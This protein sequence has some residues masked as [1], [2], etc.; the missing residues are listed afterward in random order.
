M[1]GD[2]SE[3]GSWV[4]A[5]LLDPGS[6]EK[7][8]SHASDT[9]Q[10]REATDDKANFGGDD[11][12]APRNSTV[13]DEAPPVQAKNDLESKLSLSLDDLIRSKHTE[14]DA[15]WRTEKNGGDDHG[16]DK[17][18]KA[19]SEK[20]GR[21]DRKQQGGYRLQHSRKGLK[22]EAASVLA[23]EL[24]KDSES[25]SYSELDFSQNELTAE[26]FRSVVEV[27]KACAGNLK[28]LK[29][30]K[31]R[32]GDG[33]ADAFGELLRHCPELREVHLSHN[34]LSSQGVIDLA[35]AARRSRKAD[36]PL[37]LR[38]EQNVG[39]SESSV[40]L[41]ILEKRCSACPRKSECTQFT[42]A[43]G[44]TLHVPFLDNA[45]ISGRGWSRGRDREYSTA[46]AQSSG[47]RNRSRPR[48]VFL[49]S[50]SRRRRNS[51][52]AAHSRLKSSSRSR[53]V[54]VRK[55]RSRSRSRHAMLRLQPA[56]GRPSPAP[57]R[58][59]EPSP[60]PLR[61]EELSPGSDT[62]RSPAPQKR[63]RERRRSRSAAKSRADRREDTVLPLLPRRGSR[64]KRRR[65]NRS[66]DRTSRSTR[67]RPR[68]PPRASRKESRDR[69]D[70]SRGRR[71]G[72]AKEA[73]DSAL[74]TL[75]SMSTQSQA[76]R[77]VAPST[78]NRNNDENLWKR[79]DD[80]L[81]M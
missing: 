46:G 21:E 36:W 18:W 69:R 12:E 3:P 66:R 37:W 50:P 62:R 43:M 34:C 77:D 55:G 59:Q 78:S 2:E 52:S 25:L 76:C 74:A 17:N 33:A 24:L 56:Q 44:S 65:E 64:S 39:Q 19:E 16:W 22:D 45:K 29:L 28:V 7:S 80:L 1:L 60:V 31:N 32:I 61:R 48:E 63:E 79:L 13:P 6:K 23:S 26:G 81:K 10:A 71:N 9:D 20:G 35:D 51:R 72:A 4:K 75:S 67:S 41:S 57:R 49:R 30:F 14:A 54:E 11:D 38:V 68:S 42:C 27:C 73:R 53:R 70:K 5:L 40:L 8:F 47:D 15:E 58:R